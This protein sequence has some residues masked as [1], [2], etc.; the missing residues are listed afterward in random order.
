MTS[1]AQ[2]INQPDFEEIELADFSLLIREEEPMGTGGVDSPQNCPAKIH[3]H[4]ARENNSN[5]PMKTDSCAECYDLERLRSYLQVQIVKEW[6]TVWLG[7][8]ET[9]QKSYKRHNDKLRSL[10]CGVGL[11]N[12]WEAEIRPLMWDFAEYRSNNGVATLKLF[13][14]L[15]ISVL[16]RVI[17]LL[18]DYKE[19]IRSM[20]FLY[21]ILKKNQLSFYQ[22]VD[23]AGGLKM[24]KE[25]VTLRMQMDS[26]IARYNR[27]MNLLK[28][29]I[30]EE[31]A[32]LGSNRGSGLPEGKSVFEMAFPR[33]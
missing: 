17:C 15:S 28:E 3:R 4:F 32:Q 11:F 29:E 13:D 31:A 21:S 9:G 20:N 33:R 1:N 19:E 25:Y 23:F 14:G 18:G 5:I 7:L 6:K 8:Y 12:P 16:H 22:V 27:R 24:R 10:W 30:L 26:R 2:E